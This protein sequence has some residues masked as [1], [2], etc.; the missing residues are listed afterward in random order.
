[1]TPL[2]FRYQTLVFGEWD[3][4]LRTLRDNQQF[5]DPDGAAAALGISSAS[6]PLFGIVWESGQA[7]A[8]LMLARDIAGQR[9]LEVG[10][11]IG[12]ASLLLNERLADITATDY[13]PSAGAF[14]ALNVALN[15]GREIPFVRTG[16]KEDIGDLGRFDQIIG[17]DLLYESEHAALLSDFIEGHAKPTCE[18]NIV[19][20]GRGNSG[21][22]SRHM[23]D[24]GFRHS[25]HEAV[26]TNETSPPYKGTIHRYQRV[27]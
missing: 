16:W 4:H 5:A 20:P 12:L 27:C 7:L 9:I 11:G 8:N 26:A 14:L 2:R 15:N 13:H 21:R 24:H 18:V 6:W 1:M 23:I 25:R 17:S 3:I 22:F 10:C 19:D